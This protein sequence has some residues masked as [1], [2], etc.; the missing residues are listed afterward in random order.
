V[1]IVLAYAGI[2]PLV[3]LVISSAAAMAFAYIGMRLAA[4]R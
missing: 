2:E 3:A 4:F 1:L